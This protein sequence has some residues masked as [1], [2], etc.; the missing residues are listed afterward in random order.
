MDPKLKG[1]KVG[2]VVESVLMLMHRA[3]E[4]DGFKEFAH[5]RLG[6]FVIE[7]ERENCT[8]AM[9]EERAKQ[10]LQ[11]YTIQKSDEA[12]DGYFFHLAA[13]YGED[14][15]H[16]KELIREAL[17]EK[18]EET[19]FGDM[20]KRHWEDIARETAGLYFNDY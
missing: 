8:L 2:E 1:K 3:D 5:E 12:A 7:Q 4:P 10:L 20:R 6:E 17:V 19:E 15:D 9:I 11:Q 13:V 14:N 18:L 16:V